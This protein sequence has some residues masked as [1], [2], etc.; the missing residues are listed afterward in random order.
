VALHRNL[1][2]NTMQI[3][4]WF[5]NC[6]EGEETTLIAI[7]LFHVYGMV[8]GM[9][10]AVQAASSMVLVPNARELETVIDAID[11]YQPTIFPGV[12]R[13]YNAI[14]NYPGIQQHNLRS[15]KACISGSAP[16]LLEIKN[17]F[18]SIT[19]GSLVEGYGM[20]EAP[21]ATHCNPLLGQ[22]K[23]GSIG[24]PFPDVECRIVSLEDETTVMGAGDIGELCMRGP[25]VMYGYHDMPTETQ[26][27]L[28]RHPD[29]P[30][31]PPWLHT[32]DIARMDADGYFYI[33]DRKKELIKAGGYQVWPREIEEVVAMH[34]AV[35]EVGAAGIPDPARGTETV[36]AWV[37]LKPGMTAT[38]EEIKKFCEDKLAPFKRPRSIEFRDELPKTLV[39]KVLR[40]VLVEEEK[41]KVAA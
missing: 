36:K 37:V 1:V 5:N 26:N 3:R 19:G 31:G 23:E 22:N 33:V 11:T 9:S 16:L 7:P 10:F 30:D 13:L 6:R 34:P 4:A 25:Q 35:L 14:N 41:K 8:A 2:A 29:D 40:R 28:R 20:S 21:T 32:G 24:L 27:T 39:G 18:E 17:K 38:E 12:P 15:I